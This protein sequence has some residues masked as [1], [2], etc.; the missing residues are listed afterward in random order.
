MPIPDSS[1]LK[2]QVDSILVLKRPEELIKNIFV[3]SVV[4]S[5]ERNKIKA[6]KEMIT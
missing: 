1:E 2:M 4:L 3:K 6:M 5:K